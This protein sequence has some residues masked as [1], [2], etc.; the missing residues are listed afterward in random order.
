MNTLSSSRRQRLIQQWGAILWPSFIAA[1]LASAVFF[2]FVDPLHLQ[3]ISFPGTA[4]SRELGYTAGFF[5][6]WA[7]TALSSAITWCLQRPVPAG[8]DDDELP[9]GM[10]R[11]YFAHLPQYM[12]LHETLGGAHKAGKMSL[13]ETN[14]NP[15]GEMVRSALQ[16]LAVIVEMEGSGIHAELEEIHHAIVSSLPPAWVRRARSAA[17]S[18][19]GSAGEFFSTSQCCTQVRS[20]TGVM[21]WHAYI[22]M[23]SSRLPSGAPVPVRA[24]AVSVFEKLPI[25]TTRSS[26]SKAESRGAGSCSKSAPA[27]AA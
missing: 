24:A 3:A 20:S 13:D 4:I 26:P 9:L 15:F 23:Q 6:F 14:S 8:D 5:M 1:G 12:K 17:A 22:W 10:A 11:G 27:P 18:T 7:V 19:A 16:V 25:W 2:A 21:K